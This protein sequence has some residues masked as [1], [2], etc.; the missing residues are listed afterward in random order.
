MSRSCLQV[1]RAKCASSSIDYLRNRN[2]KQV[3]LLRVCYTRNSC[4]PCR[5]DNG[6]KPNYICVPRTKCGDLGASGGSFDSDVGSQRVKEY[7]LVMPRRFLYLPSSVPF[8]QFVPVEDAH[9]QFPRGSNFSIEPKRPP[10]LRVLSI[11]GR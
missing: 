5:N 9:T 2:L 3:T 6:R 11:M 10:S 4:I 7:K 1:L 8:H